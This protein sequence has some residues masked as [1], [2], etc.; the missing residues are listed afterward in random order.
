MFI[1]GRKERAMK[2][3]NVNEVG[4][5]GCEICAVEESVWCIECSNN[6][7]KKQ[8]KRP[9]VNEHDPFVV[10]ISLLHK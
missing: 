9:I 8:L 4:E 7:C 10:K 1:K 3:P 6:G 2:V 5:H